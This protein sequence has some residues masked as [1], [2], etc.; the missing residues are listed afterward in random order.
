MGGVKVGEV[1]TIGIDPGKTGAVGLLRDGGYVAAADWTSGP[2][3]AGTLRLWLDLYPV[4]LVALEE[5]HSM[6]KQGVVSS[7][8]FGASWGWW[9][10]LLDALEAP[11]RLV[12]PQQWQPG[13][14]G[15]KASPT[16]KPGLLVARRLWPE[17]PLKLAKHHNRADALLIGRWAWMQALG[18]GRA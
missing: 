8:S 2:E 15:K 11:W 14:I 4:G 6:P 1:W 9:V 17:A 18:G 7:F 12:R 3:V 13:F 10:G 5:V 16:D